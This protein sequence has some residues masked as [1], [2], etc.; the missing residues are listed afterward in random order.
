[1]LS[2]AAT[3]LTGIGAATLLPAAT[4]SRGAG[5]HDDADRRA[6]AGR[7]GRRRPGRPRRARRRQG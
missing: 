7:R 4:D 1:M 3:G 6:G 5:C 2:P